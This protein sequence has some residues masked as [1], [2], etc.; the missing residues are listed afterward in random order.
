MRQET[1]NGQKVLPGLTIP[2]KV[3]AGYQPD[4]LFTTIKYMGILCY[5]GTDSEYLWKIDLVKSFTPPIQLHDAESDQKSRT[6]EHVTL[7][8]GVKDGRKKAV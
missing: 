3:V 1:L 8:E 5:C 7:K 6:K 4:A 2:T